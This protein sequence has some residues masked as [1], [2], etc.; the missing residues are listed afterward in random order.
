LFFSAED[1][2]LPFDQG[3]VDRKKVGPG[4]K[5]GRICQNQGIMGWDALGLVGRF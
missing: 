2:N 4:E 3:S 5:Y 1:L